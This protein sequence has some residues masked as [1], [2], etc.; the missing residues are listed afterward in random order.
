MLPVYPG[1]KQEFPQFGLCGKKLSPSDLAS[2]YL[3][4]ERRWMST[5]HSFE[6]VLHAEL[7]EQ[8][9]LTHVNVPTEIL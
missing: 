9:P 4:C 6:V 8:L 2:E 1:F 5:S 3:M 7:F